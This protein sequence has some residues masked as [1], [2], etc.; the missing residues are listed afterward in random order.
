MATVR[1][2]IRTEMAELV[3][4]EDWDDYE[5]EA[6][7]GTIHLGFL[8][9][10]YE[11]VAPIITSFDNPDW[12][13]WDGGKVGGQP[14]WL[15]PEHIPAKGTVVCQHCGGPMSFMLQVYCPVDSVEGAF[16]RALYLFCCMKKACVDQGGGSIRALRCQLPR[17]NPYYAD[18]AEAGGGSRGKAAVTCY[19]CGM[20]GSETCSKCKAAHY[21]SREHQKAHWSKGDHK[22]QCAALGLR[23][24]AVGSEQKLS[25]SRCPAVNGAVFPEFELLVEP[26]APGQDSTQGRQLD[27]QEIEKHNPLDEDLEL[28]QQE[29][30]SMAG[31]VAEKDPVTLKFLARMSSRGQEAQVLRYDRWGAS[32]ALW[33]KTGEVPGDGVEVPH[34]ERC[35]ARRDF[36]L[37]VMPQML[38][39][40]QVEANTKGPQLA[41]ALRQ[42][43]TTAP[44]GTKPT[45]KGAAAEANLFTS[46]T[47]LDWGVLAVYTCT[48]SCSPVVEVEAGS[49]LGAYTEVRCRDSSQPVKSVLDSLHLSIAMVLSKSWYV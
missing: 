18:D 4:D 49:G 5:D 13:D 28:S 47:S 38:H 33:C 26:E 3:Q 37:Q 20:R 8:D 44:L 48:S 7:T 39:Y 31:V 46:S 16:H 32:G 30:D 2:Y 17:R 41:E 25:L 34:C 21:C 11:S 45:V 35:G 10:I 29:L 14:V 36:E 43:S 19:V 12:R 42:S 24:E 9:P 22:S 1:I 6:G 40:L 23:P 27:N 15:D